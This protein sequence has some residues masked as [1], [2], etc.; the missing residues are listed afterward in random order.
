M[1][2]GKGDD[3]SGFKCDDGDVH[4]VAHI[5]GIDK[6]R[7]CPFAIR[8]GHNS[9]CDGL[10]VGHKGFRRINSL[11]RFIRL[12]D[13]MEPD[14]RAAVI[15]DTISQRRGKISVSAGFKGV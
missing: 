2:F 11:N 7:G 6:A 12:S 9:R 14:R 10:L 5:G 4:I 13:P 1:R 8:A 15:C 3:R